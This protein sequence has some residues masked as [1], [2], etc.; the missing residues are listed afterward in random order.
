MTRSLEECRALERS[1]QVEAACEA[2]VESGLVEEAGRLLVD[3]GRPLDAAELLL[4]WSA[5]QPRP[6]SAR[7]RSCSGR[8][9]QIFEEQR[10]GPRAL[11]IFA[12]LQDIPA[13][14]AAALRIGDAGFAFEAGCALARYGTPKQAPTFLARTPRGDER[15]PVACLE[16]IRALARGATLTMSLDRW[17]ADFIRRGPLTDTESEAFYALASLYAGAGFVE[18]AQEV[19]DRLLEKRPGYRDAQQVRD[20]LASTAFGSAADLARVVADDQAFAAA[21][22]FRKAPGNEPAAAS[23]GASRVP[24]PSTMATP[25]QRIDVEASTLVR[26]VDPRTSQPEQPPVVSSPATFAPGSMVAGR[27][28]VLGMVGKGGMSTVFRVFDVELNETLALKL[29]TQTGNDEAVERFRQEIRLAR[30]LVHEN[31]IRMYDMGVADGARFLTME[32][33]IGE[34][35]HTKMVSGLAPRE[36][37][38]LIAQACAGL[39]AV[40]RL[41]VIHRDVKP[42]NLFV[43]ESNIVKVMDFGIAKQSKSAGIT[44]A[45]M[46]VGTPEYMAPEQANGRTTVTHKADLYSIGVVLYALATGQLPFRH[47]ELVPLLMMHVQQAPTPPRKLNPTC[48]P[49]FEALILSLLA[50]RPEDRPESAAAVEDRLKNLVWQGLLG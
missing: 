5:R 17:L 33:L 1:G 31:V 15:Y 22:A 43:T 32:L 45:G 10:R 48:P 25:Q 40:H 28:R 39:G 8:A 47:A 20:R 46:V 24:V 41:G 49:E 23:P 35:L 2:Y 27:Y 12:W 21:S 50:K 26:S 36:G 13:L 4:S 29:F 37:A 11:E 7:A 34:D 16:A 9:A 42:E 19:L 3:R 44:M 14:D 18:N 6:L 30:Q 38:L